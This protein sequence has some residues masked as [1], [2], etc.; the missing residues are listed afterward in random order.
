M[1]NVAVIGTQWGDEGKGKIV[2]L[3]TEKADVVARF[4]GGNNAGHTLVV[5][6]KKTIL[7]LIPSGILHDRK[8][9]IIGNGVVFDPLVFLQEIEELQQGNL[10]PPHTKLFV[11]EK[12]HL[13]MPY[14]RSIDQAREAQSSGKKIGTTGRGIGPAYEDKVARTGIRIGDLYEEDLFREKLK[15]I[16]KEKNFLLTNYYKDKPLDEE[17][18][19]TQYLTCAQ[20]IKPYVADTSLILDHEIKQ[21]KKILFEGAQGSQL[22]VDHGTYPYVTSSNTVSGNASCGNGIG[23]N[24][25][26]TI[27]GICKAYTTRVGEGPFPTELKD[28]VGN[29]MQQ[30]GQEFGATTGRKRRCGWLDIVLVRQAVRVSGINALA[31]TKLDVLSGLD[32]LKIC[33]GYKS[34]EGT[35]TH[36]VPASIRVLSDCQ[37]VYEEFDGWKEDI[38]YA[39]EMSEL[40]ANARKY[41]KRLEELA[42]AKIMLVSVG[43]GR[44]ETIVLEDPFLNKL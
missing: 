35:F 31:I 41:L 23:P 28:D 36:A 25:I 32:K 11:S 15:Q 27:V 38:L 12:A 33:V 1:A 24:K 22:D 29:H 39:R 26:N 7:H 4:Q 43:A 16:L 5:N 14:H 20:K 30:V 19:A 18:I 9:C 6:G 10:L 2:D 34:A 17:E 40:P 21:G 37:P 3:Y 44:E 8:I 42:E 13:I